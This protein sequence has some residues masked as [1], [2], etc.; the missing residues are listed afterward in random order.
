[1]KR[2]AIAAVILLVVALL[3]FR[4]AAAWARFDW[5]AFVSTSRRIRIG[6]VVLAVFLIYLGYFLRAVRWT[7]LMRP[8]K[9]ARVL[10][11]LRATIIGFAALA[12]L[13]RSAEFVRP[14]LISREEGVSMASQVAVWTLERF[15]D[16]AAA[17]ILIAAAIVASP[18]LGGLPYMG[19]FRRASWLAGALMVLTAGVV[20]VLWRLRLKQ[21]PGQS[22]VAGAYRRRIILTL[23]RGLHS[24]SEG[25][26]GLRSPRAF[27][28]A[29][30]LS[31]LMWIAIALAYFAVVRACPLPLA[32]MT[33]P[34]VL[35]L[36]GF[37]LVGS[38][39]QLPGGG[40]AQLM[41][42]AAL[43]N[44]F[45]VPV[46]LAVVCGILLW[47]ATYMAPLPVGLM[48]LRKQHFSLSSIARASSQVTA[49]QS[50]SEVS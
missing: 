33:V 44:V 45:A 30:A 9:R 15:F 43:S 37:S 26:Q 5:G 50:A 18:G 38:L 22:G 40:A 29:A 6:P 24:F 21:L 27:A 47:L 11:L 12:M 8:L 19:Q 14:Y 34:A 16:L 46:E 35:L 23:E 42:I 36:M 13:G 49:S 41:V 48:L 3:F 17:A 10:P 39:V 31:L 32:S 28:S 1:M 2:K 4:E 20:L 25:L 7:V